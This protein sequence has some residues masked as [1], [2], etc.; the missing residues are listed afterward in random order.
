ECLHLVN[1]AHVHLENLVLENARFNALNIDDGGSMKATARGI[2]L[3][4]LRIRDVQGRG[5]YDGIKLSGLTDFEV[6]DC[7]VQNWGDGGSAI[8]MVG[9]RRG[10]IR[11][12]QF[13]HR[14]PTA[15][16]TGIQC[17]GGT[18]DIR[19]ERC[20]F[21]QAGRRAINIGGSTDLEVF[22][23]QPPPGY[24]AKNIAVL[25]NTFIGSNAPVAF[26]G[27]DACRVEFNTFYRP[28]R[29]ALRILQETRAPGFVPCR[30][31][32]FVN[33]LIVFRSD[34]MRTA[35]N[36]GSGTE[37][38]SFLFAGNWWYC[39]DKPAASRP[40]L[41]AAESKGL[42]GHD[43][44]LTRIPDDRLHLAPG[45]SAR[46]IGAERYARDQGGRK[47]PRQSP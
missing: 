25:G 15:T 1:P 29:W 24:E 17:K 4:G 38:G 10:V 6:D 28:H 37:A 43:P 8:D 42:Y 41:P 21:V 18:S 44:G 45:S 13:R 32:R 9:C 16:N 5:N 46:Q 47:A 35:V 12:C 39:Q 19:I 3:T 14:G 33:N 20:H 40:Q 34:E 11:R 7:R 2:R 36:V 22:R 27:A 26:V 23:P 31:G 30:N